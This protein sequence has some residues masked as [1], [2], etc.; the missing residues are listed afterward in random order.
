MVF[1]MFKGSLKCSLYSHRLT[2]MFLYAKVVLDNLMH[3]G[4]EAEL[5]DELKTENFPDGLSS[6]Y[7]YTF[8]FYWWAL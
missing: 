8:L 5:A 2:G 7:G 6:A 3:Q 4:S 1:N